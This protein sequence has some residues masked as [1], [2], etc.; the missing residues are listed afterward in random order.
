VERY[1][2]YSGQLDT[3]SGIMLAS[4]DRWRRPDSLFEKA[5]S[6]LNPYRADDMDAHDVSTLVNKPEN[7]S[8]E[9]IQPDSG[10]AIPGFRVQLAPKTCPQ[11]KN[12]LGINNFRRC[13][14]GSYPRSRQFESVHR[15]QF[16][17]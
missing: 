1:K 3:K 14:H 4:L 6:V 2:G 12:V 17:L 8:A 5:R 9:C 7:D 13:L 16:S 15:H 11:N 10:V